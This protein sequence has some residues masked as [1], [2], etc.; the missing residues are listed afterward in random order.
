[1][2]YL[3]LFVV[4]VVVVVVALGVAFQSMERAKIER[5]R[6]S[7]SHAYL[8]NNRYSKWEK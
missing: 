5:A 1:M 6:S 4:V 2:F 8:N 7:V 3:I